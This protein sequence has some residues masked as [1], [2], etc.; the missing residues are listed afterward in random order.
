MLEV[1]S[2]GVFSCRWTWTN[3][4]D[5]QVVCQGGEFRAKGVV[6]SRWS[7]VPTGRQMERGDDWR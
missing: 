5:A 1:Q 2:A 7:S 6:Q 3:K 4:L